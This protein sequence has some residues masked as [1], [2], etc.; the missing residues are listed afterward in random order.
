MKSELSLF[1]GRLRNWIATSHSALP[2]LPFSKLALELFA[3][4]FQNNAAYRKI[5]EARGCTSATV[6]QW[7][8]IPAVPTAAFK[9]LELTSLTPADRTA[10]FHSSGTTEQI[11]SRHF[12]SADSLALYEASLW[13][14]FEQNVLQ[15]SGF[16]FQV[17]LEKLPFFAL[18]L[19]FSVAT[20]CFQHG[21]GVTTSWEVLGLGSRVANAIAG[22]VAYLGKLFWPVDLA[23]IYP[24]PH[25]FDPVQTGLKAALLLTISLGCVWQ[26]PRRPQLALGWLWYLGT[27][28]PIIG[29]VQVG[30][31][32]MA[33]RYTYLPLIGPVVALVWTLA[34]EADRARWSRFVFI[35]LAITSLLA[36][37]GQTHRQLSYWRNTIT[38]F[39]H[40]VAVTPG[41][42]TAHY[43]LGLGYEHAGDTNRAITCYRVAK[44]ISPAAWD[45]RRN[46]L[47]LL[48]KQGHGAAAEAECLALIA[49]QPDDFRNH[50]VLAGLLGGQGQ[51]AEVLDQLN[52]A[53]R[54]NPDSVEALNNL[55]WLLATSPHPDFRDGP[56]A[57]TL[58]RHAC[59]L[60]QFAKTIYIGTLGAAYAEAGQFAEAVTTA[61]RACDLAAKNGEQSL[62]QRNQELLE[63][64][65]AHQSYRQVR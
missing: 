56:R 48:Q 46:L 24:Y 29:L 52:E 43:I 35:V 36:L 6:A 28:V 51:E 20:Y 18:M 23:A 37:A 12:H 41:N 4:Q 17:L 38:L 19:L 34:A 58:A 15:V 1:A 9:S 61:Q 53:V 13:S 50:L 30:E 49:E 64:Y 39:A 54:L 62:L 27:A 44:N 65:Q 22:Y 16:R 11:P 32:S 14:W 45:D 26:L 60:T 33:D 40:N 7:T 55:A 10:V 59:E 31:Q 21:G 63:C 25:S 8:Q 42:A 57:V 3:L 2:S 5:C 47:S